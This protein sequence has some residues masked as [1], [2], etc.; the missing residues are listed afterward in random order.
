VE[1]IVVRF[2]KKLAV[3]GTGRQLMLVELSVLFVYFELLRLLSLCHFVITCCW[4]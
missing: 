1:L 3:S 4:K 2:V